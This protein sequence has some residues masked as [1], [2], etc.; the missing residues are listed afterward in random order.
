[1]SLKSFS[2]KQAALTM[3]QI[4]SAVFYCHQH[5][6][7][8]R[9]LKPENI[10]YESKKED[11]LL[12][13]ID[14]GTS[15]QFE[16]NSKM[17]QKFGTA[18]YIAPEV[19]K[20]KYNEKCDI[21]SCGVILYILLCGYPPFNG[22]DDKAIMEK[23]S[24]GKYDF[25][26]EEWKGVTPE[27][28]KFIEKMMEIDVNKRYSAEQAL[29][30]PWIKKMC[31]AT[32]VDR[33]LAISALKNLKSF[34]AEKKLQEATW[35]F[36]VTYMSTRE[37]K[38]ELL[39]TF[40]ALDLNGDGQLTREELIEGYKKFMS[41]EEAEKEVDTI[42]KAVDA[43]GSGA[44][45]Y[46]EFVMAT[47]NRQKL[48]SKERLEATFK[49]FDKDGSGYLEIDEIKAIFNPNGTQVIADS[50]WLDLIKEVDPNSDGKISLSEFKEM[51]MKLV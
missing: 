9:D 44:L 49:M 1:M 42:L 19:L 6:I 26:H 38:A 31:G 2:E 22:A 37:E 4:L 45:D 24:A 3:K 13:I 18:Y 27:A 35:V 28:K 39:K 51:M 48:L 50:V 11:A 46:S 10:L 17:N 36:L 34:R 8:H 20:R 32:E 43:N 14:F 7:V 12:K 41:S 21:W 30:D 40:Q 16:A 29:N 25:H 15:K 47:I 23:V 5:N 33:P